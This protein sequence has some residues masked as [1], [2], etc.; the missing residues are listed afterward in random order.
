MARIL[1]LPDVASLDASE[2]QIGWTGGDAESTTSY[3]DP[4]E[5]LD[6]YLEVKPDGEESRGRRQ[7]MTEVFFTNYVAIAANVRCW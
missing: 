1:N 7:R 4:L 3:F 2:K 5:A 6:F